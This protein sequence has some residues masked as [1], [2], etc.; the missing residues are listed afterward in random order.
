MNRWLRAT[1]LISLVLLLAACGTVDDQTEQS[2]EATAPP[3][4]VLTQNDVE[5]ITPAAARALV[6]GGKAV[7]YDVRSEGE[8]RAQH[9]V[10][11]VLFP[12]TDVA[13]HY[14]ELPD[15]K[16]LVFY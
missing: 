6:A 10:G 12:D 8:Y 3:S 4:A 9:A 13:A 1:A 7:L 5:R 16:A 15:D 11:A 2:S 14:S